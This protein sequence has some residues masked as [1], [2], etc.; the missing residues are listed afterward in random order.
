MCADI[1][2]PDLELTHGKCNKKQCGE[3]DRD[4]CYTDVAGKPKTC[5]VDYLAKNVLDPEDPSN[6]YKSIEVCKPDGCGANWTAT[7]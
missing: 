5:I 4:P 7:L 3:A 2:D 6:M 1:C